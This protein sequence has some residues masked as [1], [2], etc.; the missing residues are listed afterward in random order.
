MPSR[1]AVLTCAAA[2]TWAL[3][4]CAQ[5]EAGAPRPVESPP[6]APAAPEAPAPPPPRPE[7]PSTDVAECFDADCTLVVTGPLTIP[8]DAARFY[9]PEMT[10]VSV[11]PDALTYY[12][13]YPDGGV[14][15]RARLGPG[16]GGSFGSRGHATVQ[17]KLDSLGDG[18][19]VVVLTPAP[20]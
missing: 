1:S 4:G 3:T 15:I 9:Y 17:V 12:V 2:V 6:T 18:T 10:L 16:G 7:P 19:T 13:T 8:L 14:A 20:R 11:T 5:P